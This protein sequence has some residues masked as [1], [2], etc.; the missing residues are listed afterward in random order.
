V[1]ALLVG[2]LLTGCGG[3][4]AADTFPD[5]P[6]TTG[7]PASSP[8]TVAP[9]TPEPTP[10]PA[11]AS[12]TPAPTTSNPGVPTDEGRPLGFG[13]IGAI[14]TTGSGETCE[15]CLWLADE[16][17]AR[18]RGLMGVTDLAGAEGMAFRYAEPRTT[19]FTMRNTVLPLSIAFFDAEG[20]FLDAF[21]MEPCREEPCPSYPTPT[22]FSIAVEVPVGALPG[23]GIGPGATLRT[24]AEDCDPAA[25]REPIT[26]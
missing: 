13:T 11:A 9:T 24:L 2:A 16:P 23:L 3:G 10:T 19:A 18:A 26:G 12:S 21:D 5:G 4:S 20:Q 8:P 22:G 25:D 17:D 1:A 7:G 14:V 6:A 15:L